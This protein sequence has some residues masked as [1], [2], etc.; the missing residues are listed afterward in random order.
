MSVQDDSRESYMR[1][2]FGLTETS[3]RK[4]SDVDA[5]H[6]HKNVTLNF[7]LK[8]T[9]TASFST[10][11]DL[12]PDH[13]AKWETM[14]WIFGFYDSE[15]QELVQAF[16]G[17][18]SQMKPWVDSVAAYIRP[19][20]MLADLMS[21]KVKDDTLSAVLGDDEE[22]SVDQAKK[23]MKKQWNSQ[24]YANNADL[25]AGY[26]REAMRSL[27]SLRVKYLIS[28]GSTLNNPHIN[29][30]YVRNLI[31]LSV[32]SKKAPAS[33]VRALNQELRA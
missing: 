8:S 14:H 13:I 32:D 16:Y 24:D 22:F 12:G 18:P 11:R 20:Q 6:K 17:S 10:V 28:R 3:D 30:S 26:S 23:I 31:P 2:I 7:E 33:L 1:S 21:K 15:G 29:G 25:E 27:L 4:R 19:D 5:I 9:T